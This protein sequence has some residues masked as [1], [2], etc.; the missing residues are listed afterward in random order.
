[1]RGGPTLCVPGRPPGAEKWLCGG[2]EPASVRPVRRRPV[3]SWCQSPPPYYRGICQC[4]GHTEW[5]NGF[6]LSIVVPLSGTRV[7][8]KMANDCS[9]GACCPP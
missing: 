8:M 4:M 9:G 6:Q 5:R 1:M 2:G 3:A 7:R